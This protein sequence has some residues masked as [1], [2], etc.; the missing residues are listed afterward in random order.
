MEQSQKGTRPWES[1]GA[2]G[3][4]QSENADL[5]MKTAPACVRVFGARWRRD[6]CF[7]L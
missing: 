3:D 1:W 7:R 4:R 6:L 5:G 2:G